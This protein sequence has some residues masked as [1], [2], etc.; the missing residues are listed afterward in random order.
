M[1]R[2][3]ELLGEHEG[4]VAYGADYSFI[5]KWFFT[6]TKTKNVKKSW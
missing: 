4:S 1:I 3:Q 5:T 2:L 6:E